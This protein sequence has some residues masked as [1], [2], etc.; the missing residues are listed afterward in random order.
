MTASP[1]PKAAHRIRTAIISAVEPLEG[2]RLMAGDASAV[3]SLPFVLDFDGVRAGLSDKDGEGTGFTW[4]QVNKDGTEYQSGL[5]DLRTA[6]G[7]LYLTTTGT[8]IA[9]GPFENDNTLVNG[10][11]IQFNGTGS[12][13]ITVRLTGPLLN[14]INASS[15]QAGILFGPDQDNYIK[16]VALGQTPA[17][18]GQ[19]NQFLQFLDEYGVTSHTLSGPA[20]MSNIGSFA[21]IDTLD[22]SIAGDATTGKLTA[23]YRINGGQQVKLA[24]EIT[25]TTAR[26][27][28]F[29][30]SA[31]RAG[32]I[33]MHKNDAGPLTVA[34]DRFEVT[35]GTPVTSR[36]SVTDTN[37]AAGA[38]G[39]R[40]DVFID[41]NVRLPTAGKGIDVNT[42]T[43]GTVKLVRA[44]DGAQVPANINTSGGGDSITLTPTVL[45]AENTAYT[46]V[47][48]DGL[49]D[50]AGAAF[51][52]F[53]MTFT[54]GTAVTPVDPTVAFE[55]V[56]LPTTV[57][58]Q[59]TALTIGP[60]G[61]LYAGTITG[62]IHRFTIQ[63]DG[64]LSAPQVIDIVQTSNG[65]GRMLTGMEF[66]PAST[67]SNLVLWVSHGQYAM[68]NASDFTGKVSRLS[69]PNLGTYQDYVVNLPRSVRDHLTNQMDFGPD[70]KL[71]IAQA[72]N[73]AMGAPDNAWGMRPERLLSASVLRLDT[74][75]VAAR[76]AGGQGALDAKTPDGGGTYNP[77]AAGA[78]LTIYAT[79]VRNAYDLIW[80]SNGQLYAPTNGSAAH[81][82]TPGY[83]GASPV[84]QRIDGPYTGGP[85]AGIADVT[86]TE[87]DYLHR[88]L[89][90]GYYGHPN[91]MRG[92][93]V[94]NGGNPT[95]GADIE[96]IGQYPVG[97]RPDQNYRGPAYVFGRKL[98]PNG[99]VEY[100]GPAFGGAL[101]GRLLVARFGGGDDVVA[102]RVNADGTIANEPQTTINGLTGFVDP[103]DIVV[104]PTTGNLYV[105]E[106]DEK[107]TGSR[108]LTLLRPIQPGGNVEVAQSK[109]YF[110]D[111]L[112]GSASPAKQVVIRNTGTAPLS[113]PSGGLMITGADAASF[114]FLTAPTLPL[115]IPAGGSF[116]VNVVF[117]P[118]SGMVAGSIKNA[119][120]EVRSNDADQ[121]FIQVALRGLVTKGVGGQNE[122]SLQK[123]FDLF[124]IPVNVGDANP[125][126]TDLF[127][128]T[129]ILTAASEEVPMQRLV[130]AGAGDVIIEPLAVYG[131]ASTPVLRFG[132]YRAGT[133]DSKTELFTIAKADAQSV[134][135]PV[136]GT[137]VFDPG[138]GTFGLYTSWPPPFGNAEIHSEDALN[139][140]EEDPAYRHKVRF[141]PLKNADG[142]V[143]P[144]AFVVAFEEFHDPANGAYDN[145]DIVAIVRNVRAAPA[146]PEIGLQ[147]L[148]GA[149][150]PDRLVFNRVQQQPPDP[151]FNQYNPA[152]GEYDL[153]VYPPPNIVHDTATVRVK[154]TGSVALTVQQLVLD[155]PAGWT[156]VNPPAPGTQIAPGAF[157]DV[158]VKFVAQSIPPAQ[159]ASREN[160][161][162][163]AADGTARYDSGGVWTGTLAVHTDDAD[164][165]VTVVQLAGWWQRKSELNMEPTLQVIVNR[166]FGYGT[167][168]LSAG[169]SLNQG[170]RPIAVGEEVLS[171]YWLRADATRPVTVRQ[172]V[173]FHSQGATETLRSFVK[174]STSTSTVFVHDSDEGQSLLP[175]L[176]DGA[177]GTVAAG[178]AG[179]NLSSHASLLFGLRVAGSWSDDALNQQELPGGGSGHK[180][181]FYP[182][183]DGQGRLVP[184]A[185]LMVHDYYSTDPNGVVNS[186]HD[187]QDN[188]YLV[189]NMRPGVAPPTATAATSG[190]M[191][192]A[193]DWADNAEA[194]LAGYNVYRS[195]STSS[196]SFVKINGAPVTA[197]QYL[198]ATAAVGTT[199]Y[200][201]VTAV[202]TWGSESI[203]PTSS[204]A[205]VSAVRSADTVPP[206]APTGLIATGEAAGIRVGWAAPGDPDVAG[207]RVYR[208]SSASG[209]YALLNTTALVT[210]TTYLDGATAVGQTWFYKVAAVDAQGNESAQSEAVSA[211][212]PDPAGDL[213]P[214]APA[215]LV[216]SVSHAGVSLAWAANTESD[217]AGYNVYRVAPGGS[218]VRLNGAL[219]TAL[220]FNDT[221]AVAGVAYTYRVTAV[222][223]A[224]HE[225]AAASVGATRPQTGAPSIALDGAAE[226]SEGSV[227]ELVLGAV[228]YSGTGAV[229]KYVVH[230]GDG[231]TEEFTTPGTKSHVFADG[232]II[233]D[234]SVDLYDGQ[235]TWAGA[236]TR[237]LTVRDVA[238]TVTVSGQTGLPVSGNLDLNLAAQDPGA[239]VISGWVI[240]WGDGTLEPANS[241]QLT[242]RH[243]YTRPGTYQVTASA[244]NE[245]GTFTSNT[246]TVVVGDAAPP[247]ATLS[248]STRTARGPG[249]YTFAI[250]YADDMAMGDAGATTGGAVRVTGP[251]GYSALATV[252]AVTGEGTTRTVTYSA[253]APGGAW[254]DADNGPY[255]VE[256]LP[257]MVTDLAGNA[258]AGG[259]LG[260]FTVNIAPLVPG[261][262]LEAAIDLGAVKPRYKKYVR[263]TLGAG[264]GT[265]YFR[266]TVTSAVRL[267]GTLSGLK[268]D[269]NLELLDANGNAI[270]VSA[271]PGRRSEKVAGLLPVGTYYV[272]AS[273]GAG[274]TTTAFKL[275]LVAKAP[276]R[277]DLALLA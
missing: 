246:H 160:Q 74:A 96:E 105:S 47:V 151:K 57:G 255:T 93:Y 195:T 142:S 223:A 27:A 20:S 94:L 277:R 42:L 126:T 244:T 88:I 172:L 21:G 109:V 38:T 91:P 100:R 275:G 149:P 156:L 87:P 33:A 165:P 49:R 253:P 181:R 7:L 72:S 30:T 118:S 113:I 85:V 13:T 220:S 12:F 219:V 222:D 211:Q 234:V 250:T 240:D 1:R 144:N 235:S 225:S 163:G 112:G 189:T 70:G 48:T 164:E 26:R 121:S 79:G 29:F 265:L 125:E 252:V 123:V 50:T 232:T 167:N 205:F 15:E 147:N 237:R 111:P 139:A 53:S 236:G 32:L 177:T 248:A 31:A 254:D 266:L 174:G 119:T 153:T 227:Y 150:A 97:T 204:T 209:T 5:I 92:E 52:P 242:A 148:D 71:Y 17:T 196:S 257:G 185:W 107:D 34:F 76:I 274:A 122:P 194:T 25:L 58:S 201:F 210:A 276:T 251:G 68:E 146:G 141:Y 36:P 8:S 154:N 61:R 206:A 80:H 82:A 24:Q 116:V 46:F 128:A 10:L 273:L 59:Y 37:P 243:V 4:A 130:K 64:T 3:Q 215:S 157:L 162:V 199:Y 152:T 224:A 75:A 166:I 133:A 193:L 28:A 39:V 43:A 99:V 143:V 175:H 56:S 2:R 106:Y 217:L 77:W 40:R 51:V 81:G 138:A 272:R 86:V 69:G 176:S 267:T 269:A 233:R 101:N 55:K 184:D 238:P 120:L 239:D 9:G 256:L 89:Q 45:L 18:A 180:V 155:T 202:S 104:D 170:G 262:S 186:N 73:T 208:A 19:P 117:K 60:D 63:P 98:S 259:T 218:A 183:R 44:S 159:A 65:A 198:D 131:V 268:G 62:L 190:S 136:V 264:R 137:A 213:P 84:P 66:D 108:H 134:M 228:T 260:T 214:A 124:Q 271:K 200:Y 187:Y 171:P 231:T 132:W 11:Q 95:A 197:S 161:T 14:E 241:A 16:L 54:T 114:G 192:I 207:Y 191:G 78:P 249:A 261:S 6:E 270:I 258:H 102:L 140:A 145:Q 203:K 179:G 129:E 35:A 23:F 230:W 182:L 169:Q 158:T 115:T 188:I 226:V 135:P 41:A 247:A 83:D 168:V 216:A 22:L 110:T 178:W 127:N 229:T 103:L 221:T 173:A 212:R 90:G 245:D 263:D 67:A